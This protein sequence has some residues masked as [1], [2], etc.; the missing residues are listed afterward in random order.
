MKE[1]RSL[2]VVVTGDVPPGA[3]YRVPLP[4]VPLDSRRLLARRPRQ[5]VPSVPQPTQ[6]QHGVIGQL[7]IHLLCNNGGQLGRGCMAYEL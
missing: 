3:L 7:V 4:L 2:V 5:H 1:S 6:V